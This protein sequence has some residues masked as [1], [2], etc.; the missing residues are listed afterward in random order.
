MPPF[1]K[2]PR[3]P[4]EIAGTLPGSDDIQSAQRDLDDLLKD[5]APESGAK[6]FMRG[7]S[8]A[9]SGAMVVGAIGEGM[10]GGA[11]RRAAYQQELDARTIANYL[12]KSRGL[13]PEIAA[14]E[15]AGIE[16]LLRTP[17]VWGRQ[18]A[19]QGVLNEVVGMS[20]PGL[21]A[22]R[23]TSFDLADGMGMRGSP[24][25]EQVD[26]FRRETAANRFQPSFP[27][28]PAVEP[29]ARKHLLAALR[30]EGFGAKGGI[31]GGH[32]S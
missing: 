32:A 12:S 27:L 5:D 16:R 17:D 25:Q 11:P 15:A 1:L 22:E 29:G 13:S 4:Q 14:E 7:V 19:A 24:L 21:P 9:T 8:A 3:T 23:I 28:R 2:T 18:T 20:P 30:H 31:G 26:L 6:A 10:F